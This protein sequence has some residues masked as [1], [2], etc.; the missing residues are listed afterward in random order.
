MSDINTDVINE[1]GAEDTAGL[2]GSG[3]VQT[4]T[5]PEDQPKNVVDTKIFPRFT[6]PRITDGWTECRAPGLDMY[7]VYTVEDNTYFDE[8]IVTD[9][10]A[11]FLKPKTEENTGDNTG[12]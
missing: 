1:N 6:M 11:A 3:T 9:E 10:Y 4:E 5:K 7:N 12:N 2:P 8:S